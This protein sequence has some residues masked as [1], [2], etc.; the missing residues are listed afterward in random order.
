MNLQ[1]AE[2]TAREAGRTEDGRTDESM[3]VAVDRWHNE[4]K[5]PPI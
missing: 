1:A 5:A 4:D 3:N 2:T